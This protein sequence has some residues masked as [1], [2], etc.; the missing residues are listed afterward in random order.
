MNGLRL[1]TA[2][3]ICGVFTPA[4]DAQAILRVVNA[5]SLDTQLAPGSLATIIGTNLGTSN[6]T[7]VTFG[8]KAAAVV[9]A[10][11][12]QVTVQ[13][14]FDAAPG[15]VAVQVA[16]SPSYNV[17]IT[18]YAPALFAANDQGFGNLDGLHSDGSLIDAD[19][20]AVTGETVTLYATGLG[21]TI[22][23]LATGTP[24]PANPPAATALQP[25]V[26]YASQTAIVLSS[27]MAPGQIGIYQVTIRLT[28][29]PVTGIR[30]IGINIGGASSGFGVSIP[31]VAPPATKPAIAN[32]LSATGTAD[33]VQTTIQ[34]GSWVAIYGTALADFSQDWTHAI[35]GDR[36]PTALG[37]VRVTVDGKP[38]PISY[39]SSTQVNVQAP[40]AGTGAVQVVVTYDG[41]ASVPFTAQLRS[42]APAFFQ[43]GTA[44]Y[45]V[46]TRYPDN[47][48]VGAPSLGA[49]WASAKRGD[50]LILWGTGFGPTNP[51]VVPGTIVRSA[52][53]TVDA[54]T[55]TVGGVSVPVIGAALSPG[56]AGVYQIAITLPANVPLGDVAVKATVAGYSSPDNVYLSVSGS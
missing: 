50:T 20:P 12:T 28:N 19:N 22:P 41:T 15:T 47:A 29:E 3:L 48:Y 11:P 7:P 39:I 5:A 33:S 1:T 31:I 4:L 45:A 21:P 42:Y 9:S 13:I 24:G 51:T 16:G 43:W 40:L 38:S 14:P 53:S 10:S 46:A 18:Q 55:V 54:V 6:S 49:S 56:L 27:V 26:V 30:A 34:S 36:L 25:T 2:I 44:K 23:A 52:A 17:K 8:G 32:V 35:S 37:G